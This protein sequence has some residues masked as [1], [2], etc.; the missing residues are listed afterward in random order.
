MATRKRRSAP[1]KS[2]R[3]P[4]EDEVLREDYAVRDAMRQSTAMMDRIYA[5]LKRREAT[6]R[7]RCVGVDISDPDT[8]SRR[9]DSLYPAVLPGKPA[10]HPGGSVGTRRLCRSPCSYQIR[11][12]RAETPVLRQAH[13]IAMPPG[14]LRESAAPCRVALALGRVREYSTLLQPRYSVQTRVLLPRI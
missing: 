8:H 1:R 5:D 4:W 9:L 13:S 12:N 2:L 14:P 3:A 7:L 11:A 6:G 10:V